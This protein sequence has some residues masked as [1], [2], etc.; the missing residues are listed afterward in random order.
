MPQ[1][2]KEERA[3][4]CQAETTLAR[5]ARVEEVLKAAGD[6]RSGRKERTIQVAAG[7]GGRE[8]QNKST[9]I[10]VCSSGNRLASLKPRANCKVCEG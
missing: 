3:S 7:V 8:C 9:F 10:P 4:D 5:G 2:T 1:E 6:K